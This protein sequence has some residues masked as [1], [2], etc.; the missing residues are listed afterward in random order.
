MDSIGD[1][2]PNMS[3]AEKMRLRNM[4][5]QL[6]IA[7]N[8]SNSIRQ[9]ML[10]K[11]NAD[12]SEAV[13]AD[14][15]ITQT[16]IASVEQSLTDA[17]IANQ[18]VSDRMAEQIDRELG[19]A[20]QS[21]VST[22]QTPIMTPNE[23]Y[24]YDNFPLV[25]AYA[26]SNMPTGEQLP[27]T[28]YREPEKIPLSGV[29]G[30]TNATVENASGSSGVSIDTGGFDVRQKTFIPPTVPPPTVP[31]IVPSKGKILCYLYTTD[32]YG[33]TVSI[34]Q[35]FEDFGRGC[36]AGY[37]SVPY[38]PPPPPPV[39]PPPPIG[40]YDLSKADASYCGTDGYTYNL[41]GGGEYPHPIYASAQNTFYHNFADQPGYFWY[42]KSSDKCGPSP[43]P[44]PPS[45]GKCCQCGTVLPPQF[46]WLPT[47][48]DIPQEPQPECSPGCV[49]IDTQIPVSK[50]GDKCT[51][52]DNISTVCKNAFFQPSDTKVFDDTGGKGNISVVSLADSI[53]FSW[54]GYTVTSLSGLGGLMPTIFGHFFSTGKNLFEQAMSSIMAAGSSAIATTVP[55]HTKECD[56]SPATITAK[57]AGLA[58]AGWGER[59]S[60]APL[61]YLWQ[62]TIYDIQFLA[63]RYLPT[64]PA[65]DDLYLNNILTKDQW[66]CYTRA[67]GNLPNLHEHVLDTKRSRIDARAAVFLHRYGVLKDENYE[68]IMRENGF[69]RSIDKNQFESSMVNLP[70]LSDILRF[71]VRDTE[72]K[73][74]VT[75]FQLD[76]DF[77][78]KYKDKLKLWAKAQG[79]PDDAA[80]YAWRA[81][82]EWISNTQL[83]EMVR[84]LRPGRVNENLQM[85]KDLALKILGI[86]D[87]VPGM[88][89]RLLAVSYMVINRTDIKRAYQID[90]YDEKEVL[91]RL[92]DVGYTKDDSDSILR[93]FKAEKRLYKQS[94]ATRNSAF[95]PKQIANLVARGEMSG[96]EAIDLLKT[97][98]L[99]DEY[100]NK[101]LRT[102]KAKATALTKKKC[103]DGLKRKYM[104]GQI[105]LEGT[106][107]AMNELD[108]R[109][110]QMQVLA[111]GWECEFKSRSKDLPA[112][113]N[114]YLFVKGVITQPEL[115]MRLKNLNFTESAIDGWMKEALIKQR[116]AIQAAM[117]KAQ[118]EAEKAARE[119]ERKIKEMEKKAKEQQ[120]ELEKQ[121][122]EE[123]K[124]KESDTPKE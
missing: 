78:E 66:R 25:D 55:Y 24:Y 116:E 86:N 32:L 110:E 61:T 113:K 13:A 119:R 98:E 40:K 100:I 95:T 59:L 103:L 89:E 73:A 67:L 97:M 54:L 37:H 51:D 52:W 36:P 96:N 42:S 94:L 106:M 90:A 11:I 10:D 120:K 26:L 15:S 34:P 17:A 35:Q 21:L 62:D 56:I 88:R 12:L 85:T 27:E 18:M 122:K 8:A 41:V 63:P 115:A 76:N 123:E 68:T 102:S 104:S 58:I 49:R 71:M 111:A 124:K 20:V 69:I 33:N 87:V 2:Y 84:R 65:I 109:G 46:P 9:Q 29:G 57:M 50:D 72:D 83:Y 64:Q 38:S 47:T 45:D 1:I 19:F 6:D 7:S 14:E 23:R 60:S 75:E 77:E 28:G 4:F 114:V 80:L 121:R 91:E 81:H 118:R 92:Q 70:G 44:P 82:W 74:V 31:P 39:P 112:A 105:N 16:A 3:D 79:I 53:P 117:E 108:V 93:I 43:P 22:K 5:D 101:L 30:I 48:K 107:N 99:P